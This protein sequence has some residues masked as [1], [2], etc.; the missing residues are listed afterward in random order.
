MGHD[1]PKI[2]KT[3]TT[4]SIYTSRMKDLL[5]PPKVQLKFPQVNFKELV[6]PRL[7]YKVLEVKQKDL[8]FSLTHGIYR[9][10]ARL[11]QQY[12]VEDDLCP[13]PACRRENQVQDIEHLFCGCYKVRAAWA[14]TR[15]K[16][17]EMMRNQGRPPDIS[18][19]DFILAKFPQSDHEVE[20]LLILGTYVWN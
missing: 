9:N 18:N 16:M 3:I 15:R 17:L 13:N 2:L 8:L 19:M 12:R 5:V 4:K 7:R 6:Y 10:R 14:W 20:C 11:Y 1:G